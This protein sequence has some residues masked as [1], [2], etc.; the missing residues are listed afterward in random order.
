MVLSETQLQE[1]VGHEFPGGSYTIEPWENFL[2][3][4]ATGSEPLTDGI[5]HP[6]HLFHV[7][8]AGV[9]VSIRELFELAGA[10]SDAPVT[11]D[12]Y[13]WEFFEPLRQSTAYAMRG[14][15]TA[16]E[17]SQPGGGTVV[18]ALDYCIEVSAED[19]RLIARASFR[20]LFWRFDA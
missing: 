17:R 16:H 7:P 19:E 5:A 10:A 9:G 12:F 18:D 15:V 11:I 8:I 2:L 4:E 13:D 1:L 6:I 3:T 20:W 14:G